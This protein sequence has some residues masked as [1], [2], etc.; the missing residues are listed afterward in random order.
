MG[1][2]KRK[3]PHAAWFLAG[4]EVNAGLPEA[5]IQPRSSGADPTQNSFC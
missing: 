1:M 4:S 3:S 5:P 2:P